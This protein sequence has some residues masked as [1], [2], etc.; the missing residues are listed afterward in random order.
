M[1]RH[2]LQITLLVFAL[3][4]NG[5]T[6]RWAGS[7][8]ESNHP[9]ARLASPGLRSVWG[10]G[11][12][13]DTGMYVYEDGRYILKERARSETKG[14]WPGLE[15][16]LD[17]KLL[18]KLK[19]PGVLVLP[20]QKGALKNMESLQDRRVLFIGTLART[21]KDSLEVATGQVYPFG[22]DGKTLETLRWF[23]GRPL[24]IETL[25]A[26]LPVAE[27]LRPVLMLQTDDPQ[28]RLTLLLSSSERSSLCKAA[29]LKA[30][31]ECVHLAARVVRLTSRDSSLRPY[32]AC[33]LKRCKQPETVYQ[34]A[35]CLIGEGS[36]ESLSLGIDALR[37]LLKAEPADREVGEVVRL[38]ERRT[39]QKFG[40]D[41]DQWKQ[42]VAALESKRSLK[43][44]P[45]WGKGRKGKLLALAESFKDESACRG[46]EFH[47]IPDWLDDSKTV[48]AALELT[49]RRD[50]RLRCLIWQVFKMNPMALKGSETK[51]ADFLRTEPDRM[52]VRRSSYLFTQ[53][54]TERAADQLVELVNEFRLSPQVTM[55][56]ACSLARM[57][58]R[59]AVRAA[60]DLV[61]NPDLSEMI[62]RYLKDNPQSAPVEKIRAF[63]DSLGEPRFA[64]R[65]ER[66]EN[67]TLRL[68][69]CYGNPADLKQMAKMPDI[70]LISLG[71]GLPRK[72]HKWVVD[73]A[74]NGEDKAEQRLARHYLRWAT[75]VDWRK[76]TE[77]A[78]DQWLKT[79][80]NHGPDVFPL[81]IHGLDSDDPGVMAS[82]S[83]HLRVRQRIL[84]RQQREQIGRLIR[85]VWGKQGEQMPEPMVRLVHI[86]AYPSD[87][88]LLLDMMDS[89][90][91]RLA[92]AGG[93]VLNHPNQTIMRKAV[94]KW[95]DSDQPWQ[96]HNAI[97]AALRRWRL[98]KPAYVRRAVEF[99]ADPP[100]SLPG[101]GSQVYL[102]LSK[103]A[104]LPADP[105]AYWKA[106]G[107][108]AERFRQWWAKQPRATTAPAP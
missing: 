27:M 30:R 17:R 2:L 96:R 57:P 32:L 102:M 87:P 85:R 50:K 44:D 53:I 3:V 65:R 90:S 31:E 58:H 98:E 74:V 37:K 62:L 55:S 59:T 19:G 86:G 22:S 60:T 95:I 88:E 38:L 45:A 81:W 99:I 97:L 28:L 73:T 72:V 48:A 12:I 23:R 51:V 1:Y 76:M 16:E 68:L 79:Y 78:R 41:T 71:T 63:R 67:Q 15:I 106:P 21:G 56:I 107:E 7:M 92:A 33:A 6:R 100:T 108:H 26:V 39:G 43:N 52:Q 29:L 103:L 93:A 101:G 34:L 66:L 83:W 69:W 64:G 89:N 10:V 61:D 82:S 77:K 25:Q 4:L 18:G 84:S 91:T 47:Q 104:G 35:L 75:G 14:E 8:G 24:T 105:A 94:D 5:Q 80:R 46:L 40:R 70:Q 42:W 54:G 9:A 36:L 13:T 49:D 20:Q 11:K